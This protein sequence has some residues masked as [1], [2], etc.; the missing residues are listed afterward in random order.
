MNS[1]INGLIEFRSLS[2]VY[3][4][5]KSLAAV[6]DVNLKIQTG[7]IFVLMGTSGSGK[8]TLLRHINRLIEPTSG[9]VL[10][11]G[12]ELQT[13][14]Q[15][16][17]RALRANRIG[18]VFQHFG[19][20]PHRTVLENVRL[21]LELRGS[22]PHASDQR[23]RQ[24]LALVGLDQSLHLYPDELSGGMQQ[25][26]GIARALVSDPDILLMDEPF[27][28]LDPTIRR[29]LQDQVIDLVRARRITTILVTH[30]PGEAIRM[31]DRVALLRAGRI[32]Q[33]GTPREILEHPADA[34]VAN[35][36]RGY[37][38]PGETNN[39]ASA[40]SLP[41]DSA[42]PDTSPAEQPRT[43]QPLWQRLLLGPVRHLGSGPGTF[44]AGLAA[45]AG[46]LATSAVGV[47]SASWMPAV[48]GAVCLITIRLL[49][50]HPGTVPLSRSWGLAL[51]ASWTM[52]ALIIWRALDPAR[53]KAL[54]GAS[55]DRTA[56]RA[57]SAY[58]DQAISW[59]QVSFRGAFTGT[60][61]TVRT[62][63]ES[64]EAAMTWLP[65]PVL[66]LALVLAAW[67]FSGPSASLLSAVAIAYLVLFG[68]WSQTIATIS[69]VGV[70]VL[71]AIAA[72]VP[73]GIMIARSAVARR[74]VSPLLD[75]M[76]TLPS[77]VY[78][79]PAVAFF[80]VGKT[81]AVLATVVFTIP[82][83]IRLTMLGIREVPRS[84]VEAVYAHGATPWQ[85]LT[86]VELP[87]AM[88]SL[89][90]GVN[91][92]IVM[93]LSMVVVSALIGAGGLGYDVVTA[94]RNIQGGAGI[95]AGLAIVVCALVPDRIIQKAVRRNRRASNH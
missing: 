41:D 67:R 53:A 31:A 36:F 8:S 80:S 90:L 37:S 93:S 51:A 33:V 43:G 94:L 49:L 62:V 42:A 17:L 69:L 26:V 4:G 72:G 76:Q 38:K 20:L 89:M 11:D 23:A 13:L 95:L 85:V 52:Y 88:P 84:V 30:D 82:P 18:M 70:S 77:F 81:P 50:A 7:E 54:F 79:I 48:V 65:W 5:P 34:G 78:L 29:D 35:F 55:T 66:A 64:L 2:K 44:W 9:S 12:Q 58:L 60:V 46:A 61:I 68:F 40:T 10:I 56:A 21:P 16:Q 57:M 22:D 91:Q 32:V 59:A 27:S 86:K 1:S 19:L 74:F 73:V 83:M 45:E 47:A 28:A 39:P 92:T 24:Q 63:I 71:I 6:A 15:Q 75:V 3:E 87:L 14:P 25:R